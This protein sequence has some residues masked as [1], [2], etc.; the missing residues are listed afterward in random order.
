LGYPDQTTEIFNRK[1]K[2]TDSSEAHETVADAMQ[3]SAA[4]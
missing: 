4:A 1:K 2:K 3:L